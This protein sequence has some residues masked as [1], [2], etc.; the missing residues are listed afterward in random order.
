M[1][2]N[3]RMYIWIIMQISNHYFFF[4]KINMCIISTISKKIWPV[5][6]E[7]FITVDWLLPR[8]ISV[9]FR[10][11]LFYISWSVSSIEWNIVNFIMLICNDGTIDIYHH[12]STSIHFYFYVMMKSWN[13]KIFR[14]TGH[15]CGEFSGHRWFPYTKT[16][17]A[18]LWCFFELRLNKRLSKQWQGCWF[19]TP[20]CSLWRH[21][22]GID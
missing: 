12:L 5:V 8:C 11:N 10:V 14:V 13:G 6:V 20:S 4:I 7:V 1:N 22:D 9:H 17:D 16:S 15:S 18:E 19:V 2:K 21:F 3:S